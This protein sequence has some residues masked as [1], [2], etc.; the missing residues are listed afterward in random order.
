MDASHVPV[1]AMPRME[2]FLIDNGPWSQLIRLNN[3]QLKALH[4]YQPIQLG[5]F[6]ITPLLVPHRD[7]FSE[8]VG[9]KV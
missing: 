8:T 9:F 7:E 3:I 2:R 1:Y 5:N 6:Q 4:T